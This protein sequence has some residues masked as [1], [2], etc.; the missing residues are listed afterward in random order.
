MAWFAWYPYQPNV[1]S[2]A[3]DP[4]SPA[5][6]TD[7]VHCRICQR[8]VGLW[9]FDRKENESAKKRGGG[10]FDLVKDH[11]SWCP[12]RQGSWWTDQP[13][14]SD[15]DGG[16]TKISVGKGWVRVSERMEKKPWRRV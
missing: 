15:P 14:L 13:L 4:T 12:I 8:R 16:G 7:I 10:E 6:P 11:F 3:V 9:A 5:S 2:N 1:S